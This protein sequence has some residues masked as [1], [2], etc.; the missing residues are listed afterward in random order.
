[1]LDALDDIDWKSLEH[2]YGSAEDVPELIRQLLVQDSKVRAQ[3]MW[4][5][6]GNVFHQGTRYPATPHVIPFLIELCADPTILDRGELLTFW[7]SLITGYFSV[8]ERPTWGDGTHLYFCGEVQKAEDEDP[9]S[10]ALH[11]IYL[12]SLSGSELLFRLL[13]DDNDVSVRARAAWVLACLPTLG[14]TS[15]RHLQNQLRRESNGCVRAAIA[16]ALG[17][18]GDRATLRG[19]L[20]KGVEHPAARCMATCQLA[21]IE[22]S[23]EL[24]EPLLEFI[25]EP[26]D[27]YENIPGAGG[28]STGDA[29]FSITYLP[30]EVRQRAIPAISERL[31]HARSFATIPL[32]TALLSAAF[33]QRE[34]PLTEFNEPQRRVLL[35]L[36]SAQELW[37]IGNQHWTFQ[38]YGLPHD[39]GV[40]ARLLGVQVTTDE[41]LSELSIAVTYAEMGFLEEARKGI[42]KAVELDPAVFA[43]VPKPEECW[44]Y[45]AKAYAE[46]DPERAVKAYGN[47]VSIDRNI[48]NRIVVTWKLSE[49]LGHT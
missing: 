31:E 28:E 45:C 9:Y 25:C 33:E 11:Q 19:T 47:A 38:S 49:L 32:V 17:E 18:I 6:Y 5:L 8:Q 36:L 3:V 16:F 12:N 13:A 30:N 26:I 15:I 21:R 40:C 24:I 1:M 43:R 39:R 10:E 4:T 23:D 46:T 37:S 41:A 14:D 48:G 20:R 7:G 22:P 29:A 35:G 2:A 42:D 34:E 27:G 44:L